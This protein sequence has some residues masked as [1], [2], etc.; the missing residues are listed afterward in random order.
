MNEL[1][2]FWYGYFHYNDNMVVRL[3]YL[4]GGNPYTG[5]IVYALTPYTYPKP[6]I[7]LTGILP[8][9]FKLLQ[10]GSPSSNADAKLTIDVALN[11]FW[12]IYT[13]RQLCG[14]TFLVSLICLT[15]AG[16]HTK[17]NIRPLTIFKRPL[18]TVWQT[19]PL[20]QSAFFLGS[21]DFPSCPKGSVAH[22]CW[23]HPAMNCRCI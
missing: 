21:A 23:S 5:K 1:I 8:R 20:S 3:S 4:Y 13:V 7:Y 12:K 9:Y 10:S 16:N 6:L 11:L 22:L 2:T 17:V 14:T 19:F 18:A 15:A